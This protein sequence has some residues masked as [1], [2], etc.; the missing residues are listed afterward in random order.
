MFFRLKTCFVFWG[1]NLLFILFLYKNTVQWRRHRRRQGGREQLIAPTASGLQRSSSPHCRQVCMQQ[2]SGVVDCGIQQ[3]WWQWE[4][5]KLV[6][7]VCV[8]RICSEI[9]CQGFVPMAGGALAASLLGDIVVH[10]QKRRHLV[11]AYSKSQVASVRILGP[12]ATLTR[13]TCVSKR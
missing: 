2:V 1:S 6:A 10:Q 7:R 5:A 4:A 3:I 9:M 8:A 12:H 13:M 11:Q